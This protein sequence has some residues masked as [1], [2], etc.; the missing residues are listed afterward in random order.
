MQPALN[1]T[2]VGLLLLAA[3]ASPLHAADVGV[4]TPASRH[5]RIILVGGAPTAILGLGV[6]S[7]GAAS[8]GADLDRWAKRRWV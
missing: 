4:L 2:R 7:A 6:I 5:L 1:V 3:L 8:R